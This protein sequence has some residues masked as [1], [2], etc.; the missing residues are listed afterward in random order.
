LSLLY[1]HTPDEC[2]FIMI[3]PKM[4]ELSVYEG[5]PHLLHPV[6]T[7]PKKAVVALK[8]TVREMEDRYRRM[9]K[10]GVRNITGYNDRVREA[11]ERGERLE[12]TVH[13]GFDPTSGEP[14]YET[15]EL[16]L[17]P[18][19]YIVVVIDEMADLM[20]TAG[21]EIEAAVQRLAQMARAA[22]IHVIMATQRPSVDVITGTIKANFP[23]RISYQVTSKIDSR[24]ILGEQGAEQLLGQGDLLFMAGGG[25]I[26]RLHGPFVTDAEVERVVDMLKAQGAP[27]YRQDVTEEP[28]ENADADNPE[29]FD[30]ESGGD[31]ELFDRAVEI[32]QRDRKASTSYL[33]RRLSIGYNRAATLIEQM[34]KRGIISAANGAGKREILV[35]ELE[36]D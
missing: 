19:P 28:N 3:D 17:E 1:R 24:T 7:D 36:E 6:V 30:G 22:G 12:R 5:I 11:L 23:T 34:E 27:Q 18:M 21:K 25:R 8:W 16:P 13:A 33:Q 2:R 9:S 26:R 35:D 4:L 29:L 31:S 14:I 10:L 32:V 20:I 15:R